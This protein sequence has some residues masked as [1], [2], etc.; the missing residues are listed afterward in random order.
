[1]YPFELYIAYIAW[2]TGGKRR[3]VLILE[4]AAKYATAYPLTTQYEDKSEN[5][6]R[7]YFNITDLNVA[8]LDKPSYVDTTKTYELAIEAIKDA[9][10]GELSDADVVRFLEFL[11]QRSK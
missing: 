7:R 1:M 2:D 4:T 11:E 8:G 6:R 5:V 10:I 3:P 9:K